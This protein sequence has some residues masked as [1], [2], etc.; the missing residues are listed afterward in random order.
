MFAKRCGCGRSFTREQWG[1]L[2]FLGR[3]ADDVEELEL[4]LCPE[5]CGSTIAV[6]VIGG[7]LVGDAGASAACYAA[8]REA[9]RRARYCFGV[10]RAFAQRGDATGAAYVLDAAIVWLDVASVERR[11]ARTCRAGD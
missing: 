2:R 8:A 11:L 1:A 4:R 3:Q 5:P 9:L 10:A 7:E 6:G